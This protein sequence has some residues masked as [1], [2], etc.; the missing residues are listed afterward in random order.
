MVV[1]TTKLSA[2]QKAPF[3][4]ISVSFE[5]RLPHSLAADSIVLLTIFPLRALTKTS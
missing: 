1:R 5:C 3:L 2:L 4:P